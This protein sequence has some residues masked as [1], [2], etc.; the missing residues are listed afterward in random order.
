MEKKMP[1]KLPFTKQNFKTHKFFLKKEVAEVVWQALEK[2][3]L[4]ELN[5]SSFN[6]PGDDWTEILINGQPVPDSKVPG[7]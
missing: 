3:D 5:C 4:V 7:Y 1:Y 6:D 2:G